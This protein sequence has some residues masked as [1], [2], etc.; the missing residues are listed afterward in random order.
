MEIYMKEG[1]TEFTPWNAA[2]I[3]QFPEYPL[4]TVTEITW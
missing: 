1:S 2:P 4:K 3:D